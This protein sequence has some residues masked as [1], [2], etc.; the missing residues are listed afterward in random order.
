MTHGVTML[1]KILS[2][3]SL[4]LAVAILLLGSGLL[5]TSLSIHAGMEAFSNTVT[6]IIMSAFFLGYVL[7]SYLCPRLIAQVGHIRAFSTLAA[8]GTV[9]VIIHG[10]VVDPVIWWLLR[11]ITGVSMV[12]LYLVVESWLNSLLNNRNRGVIFSTYITVTLVSL[13]ISQ[14][15]ILIYGAG[16]LATYALCAIFFALALV[17]VAV[18]SLKQPDFVAVPALN[19]RRLL[20]ISP[21]AVG[22]VLGT[23]LGNG[24]FWGL[25]AL[26]AHSIGNSDTEVAYFMSAVIFGG[27]LL[28][29]PIGHLSDRRDR[30]KV[31]TLVCFLAMVSSFS[32]YLLAPHS[33][34]GLL[35]SASLY[36]GFSF[37]V[38]SLAV[39]HANDHVPASQVV[40]A[41]RGLLLL[42]GLGAAI[43]PVLAGVLMQLYGAQVLLIYFSAVFGVLGLF[44]L[45]RM[46]IS[47][48]VPT[49]A[50][51]EFVP[52][53]RTGP[54]AVE[55]DPRAEHEAEL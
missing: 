17:P 38:Y 14:F 8:V 40:D 34:L 23:G 20:L 15:L 25:G 37:A 41:T 31:L 21:L 4:L 48:P 52:L 11:I 42:N 28:Q 44:A 49:E 2:I 54:A 35:A 55:M 36:G 24:A 32:M 3:F 47:A 10:L 7:G 29:V 45:I 13:G 26:Y 51:S 27:A 16:K 46:R 43:G 22:G 6:G 39:A 12:G 1:P 33:L 30:R 9:S 19:I 5:G 50:Q 18:T 53:S